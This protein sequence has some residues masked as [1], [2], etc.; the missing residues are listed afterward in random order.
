MTHYVAYQIAQERIA[1]LRRTADKERFARTVRNRQARTIH[2][3]RVTRLLNRISAA[4]T[5]T[6]PSRES[7]AGRVRGSR[8]S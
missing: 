3:S 7:P 6:R 2:R 5:P 1:D 8:V 4:L